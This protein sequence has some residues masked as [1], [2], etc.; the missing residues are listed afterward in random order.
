MLEDGLVVLGIILSIVLEKWILPCPMGT[1]LGTVLGIVLGRVAVLLHALSVALGSVSRKILELV[2]V[3]GV[4]M[5]FVRALSVALGTAPQWIL[6]LEIVLGIVFP[7]FGAWGLFLCGVC[8]V[9][10]VALAVVMG[11][12]FLAHADLGFILGPVLGGNHN[13]HAFPRANEPA[14]SI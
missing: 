7:S 3:L 11:F 6:E 1:V 4:V 9:L 8:L 5:L 2:V 13:N 12:V 10:G 14:P